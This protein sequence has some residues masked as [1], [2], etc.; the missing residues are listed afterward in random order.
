MHRTLHERAKYIAD[1]AHEA[2]P[3]GVVLGQGTGRLRVFHLTMDRS[4]A[5]WDV[6]LAEAPDTCLGV[7]DSRAE[8]EAIEA[9]LIAANSE[10]RREVL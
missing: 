4:R 1:L 9:D 7:Y 10:R 6:V 2:G 5:R 8:L 3:I